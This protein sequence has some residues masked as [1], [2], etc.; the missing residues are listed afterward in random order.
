VGVEAGI[1]V[2][3]LV[4]CREG[5][6]VRI[7]KGDRVGILEGG[8][9]GLRVGKNAVGKDVGCKPRFKPETWNLPEHDEERKQ[10]WP[11]L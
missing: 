8:R 5:V 4:G 10:P 6:P 1:V 7:R 2:V 9:E 11:I 3:F